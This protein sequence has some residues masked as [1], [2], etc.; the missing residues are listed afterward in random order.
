MPN[1]SLCN[2]PMYIRIE[3]NPHIFTFISND[4]IHEITGYANTI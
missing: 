3:R 4:F 2:Q 1:G